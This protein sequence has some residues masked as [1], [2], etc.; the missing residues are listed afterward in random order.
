VRVHLAPELFEPPISHALLVTFFRYALDGRH[1]I[2]AD[3][4]HPVVSNW[5]QQQPETLRE[6]I[7]LAIDLSAEAEALEPSLTV[8]EIGRYPATD[9]TSSP[10][11][12][13]LEDARM[14]LET[15]VSLLVEDAISDRDFLMK[16]LTAEERKILLEQMRLGY[17]HFEHGGGL[18]SMR[19]RV[20]DR[21]SDPAIRHTIWVLFDS[22]AMQ[23]G[24]PSR[25]SEAL[26][27]ACAEVPHHQ[28]SRRYM[29]SYLPAR[30]L[31]AWAAEGHDRREKKDRFS[32][33]NA[34]LNMRDE[35]RHHF[36][37]KHGFARDEARTDASAGTLY[38][39]ISEETRILLRTGFGSQIGR[40]FG[41]A[42]VTEADLRRD[43]GWSEFRPVVRHLLAQ[44]R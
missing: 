44:L 25:Q 18:G 9:F 36:N 38:D 24:M 12:L 15:A 10:I 16:M 43:S 33:L 13:R 2:D 17:V 40:L 8:V 37:M 30:A 39:D 7:E 20:M 11:R 19:R 5:V 31:Q 32:L 27:A 42:N 21:Q 34:Y 1:R 3:L 28:L 23:P 35:Q 26:R 14:F 4:A 41:G 29:E 22:D 6:E